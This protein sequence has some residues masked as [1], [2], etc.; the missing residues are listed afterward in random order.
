MFATLLKRAWI[1]VAGALAIVGA[2][3]LAQAAIPDGSGVIHGCYKNSTGD[4]RVVDDPDT[5]KSNETALQ[6]GQT[7]PQGPQGEQG[8]EGEQGPQG[9]QG[10]PGPAA[11]NDAYFARAVV[12]PH[13][14][15]EVVR[16]VSLPAGN[17]MIWANVITVGDDETIGMT[18][19]LRL[20]D[21]FD[22]VNVNVSG[23]GT[24][25]YSDEGPDGHGRLSM[26]GV[27]TIAADGS[28]LNLTCGSGDDDKFVIAA[29]SALKV[30]TLTQWE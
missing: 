14:S 4:L 25:I 5:C 15:G 13:T 7:G 24:T 21:A 12:D 29:L 19:T 27:A 17:Y 3:A 22:P 23:G 26:I 10:P 8:E 28:F 20:N 16:L 18:C 6:W 9:E 1:P 30:N 11:G 2:V